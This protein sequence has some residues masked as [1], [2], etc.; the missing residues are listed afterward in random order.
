MSYFM[1]YCMDKEKWAIVWMK[2][3]ESRKQPKALRGYRRTQVSTSSLIVRLP[4]AQLTR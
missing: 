1:G 3:M 2:S 4:S